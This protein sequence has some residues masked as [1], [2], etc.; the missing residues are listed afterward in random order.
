[1]SFEYDEKGKI[2]TDVIRKT[3]TKALIQTTNE[4]IEGNIHI[5]RDHRLIDELDKK[6]TFL[7][8]TEAVIYN[9]DKSVKREASFLTINRAHIIWVLPVEE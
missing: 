3:S 9:E 4:L 8:I 1:M 5:R 7:A 2:F 6:D